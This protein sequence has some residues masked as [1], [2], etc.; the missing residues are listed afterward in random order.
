[1]E[2]GERCEGVPTWSGMGG[3]RVYLHGVRWE[4]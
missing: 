3:V 1:M 2:W 4:V